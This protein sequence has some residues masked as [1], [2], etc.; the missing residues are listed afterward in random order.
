M[1]EANETFLIDSNIL[2]YAY[3]EQPS[4]KK[5]RAQKLLANF[6]LGDKICAVSNQNLGELTSSFLVKGKG[7]ADKIKKAIDDI[8]NHNNFIKLSYNAK[9]IISAINIMTEFNSPFWDALIIATMKENHIFSIYTE[10][11]KDFKASGI[12]AVNPFS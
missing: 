10:N 1:T 9:T 3:E 12:N 8:N 2:V 11:T 7:D 6:F 5:V 4:S